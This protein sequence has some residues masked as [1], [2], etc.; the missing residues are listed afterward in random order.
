MVQKSF[1]IAG[2][3]AVCLALSLR[4]DDQEKKEEA[5]K[6]MCPVSG[7]AAETSVAVEYKGAKLFFCCPGCP[8]EFE[9]DAAKF[10]AKANHQLVGT[11]QAVAAKCPLAGRPL[12][13]ETAIDVQGVKVAFCCDNCKGKAVAAKGDEQLAL[14]FGDAAFAKGFEVKKQEAAGAAKPN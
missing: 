12:N 9:K 6:P 7:M 13:P 10:A 1:A 4:A 8:G 2:V 11:K 14:V 3:I 5:F